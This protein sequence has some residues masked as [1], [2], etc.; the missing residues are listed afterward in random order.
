VNRAALRAACNVLT[1]WRIDV[2][3]PERS[4]APADA[5]PRTAE[6]AP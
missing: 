6:A 3:E 1:G 2:W 5:S 4:G